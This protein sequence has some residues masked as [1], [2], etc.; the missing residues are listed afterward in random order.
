MQAMAATVSGSSYS[1]N[2]LE[3]KGFQTTERA[4]IGE[5]MGAK[6]GLPISLIGED[7]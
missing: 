6:S 7:S 2:M 1:S 5:Q 3:S 4:L